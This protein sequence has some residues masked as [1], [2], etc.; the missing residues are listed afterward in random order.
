[1]TLYTVLSIDRTGRERRIAQTLDREGA[2]RL[3]DGM[4]V[5]R[6]NVV[7][8]ESSDDEGWVEWREDGS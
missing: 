2:L 7:V 6:E 1:M 5:S 3:R 4:P 8:V